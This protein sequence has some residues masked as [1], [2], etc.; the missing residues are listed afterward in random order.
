MKLKFGMKYGE[1]RKRSD[2][3]LEYLDAF[4]ASP[5]K[6]SAESLIIALDMTF[7]GHKCA[8]NRMFNSKY[9]YKCPFGHSPSPRWGAYC[10]LVFSLDYRF[11]DQSEKAKFTLAEILVQAIKLKTEIEEMKAQG[12]NPAY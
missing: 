6:C 5:S 7:P 1:F 10:F 9:C 12:N 3:A 11:G 8:I 4:I 2:S